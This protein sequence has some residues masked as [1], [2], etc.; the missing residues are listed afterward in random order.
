MEENKTQELQGDLRNVKALSVDIK[1]VL[2]QEPNTTSINI[3]YVITN[4]EL[5]IKGMELISPPKET[6]S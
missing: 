5:D 4:G 6:V 1:K 2:E 3:Y